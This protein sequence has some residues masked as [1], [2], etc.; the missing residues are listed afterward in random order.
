MVMSPL[1]NFNIDERDGETPA[2]RHA[3]VQVDVILSS[4]NVYIIRHHNFFYD[5][6][7]LP[8]YFWNIRSPVISVR[9]SKLAST[10]HY[11]HYDNDIKCI[12]V[13]F[14]LTK[15]AFHIYIYIS[16]VIYSLFELLATGQYLLLIV[17]IMPLF[18]FRI[19]NC[20]WM[21]IPSVNCAFVLDDYRFRVRGSPTQSFPPIYLYF[22]L[23]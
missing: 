21:P 6:E 22:F 19:K 16:T 4:I 8:I 11:T 10:L 17:I 20:C 23:T 1:I 5:F 15:K 9:L 7:I 12:I 2:P 14:W 18:Y 13:I 3:C